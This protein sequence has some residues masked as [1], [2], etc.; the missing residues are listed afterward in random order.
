M[1]T[2]LESDSPFSS[3]AYSNLSF[4]ISKHL[5][6]AHP[7]LTSLLL[8]HKKSK[9]FSTSIPIKKKQKKKLPSRESWLVRVGNLVCSSS[10][11]KKKRWRRSL[12]GWSANFGSERENETATRRTTTLLIGLSIS[13]FGAVSLSSSFLSLSL[14]LSFKFL[15]LFLSRNL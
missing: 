5:S 1:I 9:A 15:L 4:S 13:L 6:F 2:P 14:P 12:R 7:L 11:K 8:T 3:P 10:M